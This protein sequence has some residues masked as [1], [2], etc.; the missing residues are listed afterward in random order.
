MNRRL[1]IMLGAIIFVLPVLVGCG[2]GD[3]PTLAVVGN[4]NITLED[5]NLVYGNFRTQYATAEE[6]FEGK[7]GLLDSMVI[8]RLLIN[9]AYEKNI[10]KLE[11]LARIVLANRN[12]FLLDALYQELVIKNAVPSDA[13]I[14]DFYNRL[15]YQIRASHIL[16]RDADTAQAI[17]ERVKTGENFEKLAYDY[18]IDPSAKKN[19]GDLGYF[20]WGA[21]VDEFQ[22]IAFAMEPGEVSQPVKSRFG[23]HII[24]LVD[25]VPNDLRGEFDEIKNSVENQLTGLNRRQILFNFL[26]SIQVAYK[27]TVDTATCDYL[28]YKRRELYPPNILS[29]LP[30]NDFALEHLDRNEK[31]LVLASWE[32]GQITL[33]EY[34]SLIQR[35]PRI[36]RPNFDAYDSLR[37]FVFRLKTNEILSLEATKLGLDEE[38][39]FK[40]KMAKFKEL[41]MA[42]IMRTDSI[43]RPSPP[44]EEDARSYYTESPEEFTQPMKIHV[45]E[46][47]LNDELKARQLR[48]SIK[49]LRDFKEKAAELTERPGKRSVGGDLQYIEEKWYPEIFALAKKT[50][51]GSIAGPVPTRGKYSV[52]WVAD[53]LPEQIKDFLTVK[54]EIL[55]K[56]TRKGLENAFA[57]WVALEK[58]K[59]KIELMPD[60]LWTT[61]DKSKYSAQNG[62]ESEG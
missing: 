2:S 47:Y 3:N 55:D 22:T 61:I 23:Y 12:Q 37:A 20:L 52:I 8:T 24:K 9:S 44:T 13:E 40:N 4:Q 34:L 25:K 33:L 45:Y 39:Y 56:L 5:F 32:G 17:F 15:E 26:D 53:K 7:K 41:N 31:E 27:V 58:S 59:T 29:T 43:P 57:N 42:D 62:E 1:N 51:A 48:N 14:K 49:S 46:I 38:E 6:E 36:N 60:E 28:L 54:R 10:D 35:Y 11:E 21:M 16:L 19:R 18:S 30:K 50:P